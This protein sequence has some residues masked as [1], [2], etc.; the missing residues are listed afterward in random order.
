MTIDLRSPAMRDEVIS[1]LESLA[2]PEYQRT[3]WGVAQ[4]DDS[5]YDDL[6]LNVHILYDD[7]KVLPDPTAIVG[8][9]IVDAEVPALQA[10]EH[11]LGPLLDD[12]GDSSD[13]VY[14]ADP[15]W[16]QVVTAARTALNTM[17]TA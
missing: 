6:T 9:V 14:L 15:R 1:A 10:L 11:A 7:S 3:R 12:L 17:K 4:A 2:D 8:F 16:P 5:Y 13:D